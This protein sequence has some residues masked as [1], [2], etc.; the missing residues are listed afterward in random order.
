[1]G[2]FS[3]VPSHTEERM[4]GELLALNSAVEALIR[5]AGPNPKLRHALLVARVAG[6]AKMSGWP[7]PLRRGF[8]VLM[9]NFVEASPKER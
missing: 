6:A 1:M 7:E 4:L 8:G 5:A 3:R 9:T 2:L